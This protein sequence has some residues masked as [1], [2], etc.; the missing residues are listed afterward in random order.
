M[1]G[2][3]GNIDPFEGLE[4]AAA[5]AGA[6]RCTLS[7]LRAKSLVVACQRVMHVKGLDMNQPSWAASIRSSDVFGSESHQD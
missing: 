6:N 2:M 3:Q 4:G 1:L 5:A 7:V